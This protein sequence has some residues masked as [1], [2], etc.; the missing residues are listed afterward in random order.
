MNFHVYSDYPPELPPERPAEG[1]T[2]FVC[3]SDTHSR[4]FSAV[5]PGDVLLHAGDLSRCGSPEDVQVTIN[6]LKEL[7]HPVKM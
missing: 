5:P 2:R 7:D 1:Y 3:V 6:W 4:V